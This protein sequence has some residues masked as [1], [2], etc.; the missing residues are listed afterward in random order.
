MAGLTFFV[1]GLASSPSSS[2]V[3]TTDLR[4]VAR[5]VDAGAGAGEDADEETGAG[6]DAGACGDAGA[7]DDAGACGDDGSGAT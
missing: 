1:G 6:D 2:E 7:G 5:L 3:E 4:A